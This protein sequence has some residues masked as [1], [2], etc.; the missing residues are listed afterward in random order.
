MYQ[1]W[2]YHPSLSAERT[3]DTPTSSLDFFDL[4]SSFLVFFNASVP[5]TERM[6]LNLQKKVMKLDLASEFSAH[7][8]NISVTFP[9]PWGS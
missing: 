5:T 8:T 3:A 7:L 9:L 1:T 4:S 6:F 2:I